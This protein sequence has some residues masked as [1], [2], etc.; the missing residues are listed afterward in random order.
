MNH[1]RIPRPAPAP[2]QNDAAVSTFIGVLYMVTLIA[3]LMVILVAFLAG[4]NSLPQKAPY[5]VADAQYSTWNGYPVIILIH[6][7]G[8][9]AHLLGPGTGYSFAVMVTAEGST[10]SAVPDPAGLPWTPGS[11]IYVARS[12]SGYIVTGDPGRLQGTPR[13]FPE[14]E[15]IISV[16]DTWN[17]GLVYEEVFVLPG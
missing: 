11:K 7:A 10:W 9:A 8:D 17:N 12:G 13:A 6:R 14:G 4:I 3:L 2:L 15:V 16:V 5:I 1:T